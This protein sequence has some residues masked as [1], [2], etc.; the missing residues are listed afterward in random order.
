MSL[1]SE[2]SLWTRDVEEIILPTCEELNTRLVA[3]SPIGRG[4]LSGAI[5]KEQIQ[6]EGDLR[7]KL[8]R[9]EPGTLESNQKLLGVVQT[10]AEEKQCSLAQVSLSWLLHQNPL[11]TVI[12]GARKLN[13]LQDNYTSL[14]VQL[15][16]EQI[17]RLSE[18][19]SPDKVSGLRYPEPLLATT[20]T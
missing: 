2:Y 4:F 6:E 14:Q 13:H 9:F 7:G 20:N 11:I 16:S 3:Y 1:Q 18:A 17:A 15:S 8:P 19:F 10:I 5:S 12:P